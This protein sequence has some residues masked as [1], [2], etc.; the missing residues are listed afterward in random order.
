[1]ADE[2]EPN[3]VQ[4]NTASQGDVIV[5][6]LS[7]DANST[8]SRRHD[9]SGSSEISQLS[10][11]WLGSHNLMSPSKKR[12]RGN[13]SDE[14]I[15]RASVNHGKRC[16]TCFTKESSLCGLAITTNQQIEFFKNRKVSHDNL[17]LQSA[18]CEL[19]ESNKND[20]IKVIHLCENCKRNFTA[21]RVHQTRSEAHSD[22]ITS[23]MKI[24][25]QIAR[26]E[27]VERYKR[28]TETKKDTHGF[29]KTCFLQ[30]KPAITCT[31]SC[32]RFSRPVRLSN[33]S[34]ALK[35]R[36]TSLFSQ[37]A[38]VSKIHAET[39]WNEAKSL[40]LCCRHTDVMKNALRDIIM[41]EKSCSVCAGTSSL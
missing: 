32:I 2:I 8:A 6:D 25:S 11:D 21:I 28:N 31:T 34:G 41:A 14:Y 12:P 7:Q 39:L 1:M 15:P 26:T 38:E 23:K 33:A 30:N 18:V 20:S 22:L 4:P 40:S 36:W 5:L 24:E 19:S 3:I 35:S 13:S 27:F 9:H 29:S 10:S 16:Y 17:P 37:K